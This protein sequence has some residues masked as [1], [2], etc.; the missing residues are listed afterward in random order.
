MY[1]QARRW[2]A[3]KAFES[4]GQ[5]LRMVVRLNSNREENPTAI[6]I[7]ALTLQSTRESGGPA[8]YGGAKRQKGSKVHEA[9]DPPGNSIAKGGDA[10]ELTEPSSGSGTR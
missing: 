5:F 1:Q 4:I 10:C 2:V 6:I 7:D 3:V 9:V 8:G